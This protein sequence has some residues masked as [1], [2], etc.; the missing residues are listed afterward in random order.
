MESDA[1]GFCNTF[2]CNFSLSSM[3]Q[4]A[5][6]LR[7]LEYYLISENEEILLWYTYMCVCTY[8]KYKNTNM[9]YSENMQLYICIKYVFSPDSKWPDS[10]KY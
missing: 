5:I 4:F 2:M 8:V 3:K 6:D 7:K 10:N 1:S 9:H